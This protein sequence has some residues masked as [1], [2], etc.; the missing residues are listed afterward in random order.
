MEKYESKIK[1]V[2]A[3]AEAVYTRLTD[4]SRMGE[5]LPPQLAKD[6]VATE[7]ECR[8]VT[9]KMGEL[10]FRIAERK[11]HELVK[12]SVE[13]KMPIG[14]ELHVQMKPAPDC[15]GESRLKV[16]LS[17]DIPMLLRPMIGSKLQE[18]AEKMADSMSR[19]TF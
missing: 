4:L 2:K 10:C 19:Q 16:T 14:M 6:C 5:A 18:I 8:I 13:A 3:T 7:D 17:A 11:P 1:V 9:D 12:Y 15:D